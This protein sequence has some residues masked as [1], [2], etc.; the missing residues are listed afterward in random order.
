MKPQSPD[1]PPEVERMWLEGMRRLSFA[2]KL[3]RV[4]ALNQSLQQLQTSDIKRRCPD[5]G[6][7]EIRLRLAARRLPA[8]LMRRAFGW[9]PD[10]Q[11]Y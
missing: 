2:E 6:D 10:T 1:T 8:E 9:D 5:A 4:R 11:G 3:A 7:E